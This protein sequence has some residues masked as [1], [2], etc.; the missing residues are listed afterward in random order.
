MH[1]K[2]KQCPECGGFFS[3]QGLPGHRRHKHGVAKPESGEGWGPLL[4]TLL[5]GLGI[6]AAV[7]VAAA[8]GGSVP[9]NS[10]TAGT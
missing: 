5:S 4:V 10:G 2:S 8:G 9:G 1:A 7:L 6:L 3:A